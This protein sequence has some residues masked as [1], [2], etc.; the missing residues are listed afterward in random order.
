[1]AQIMRKIE[2]MQMDKEEQVLGVAVARAP[3]QQHVQERDQRQEDEHRLGHRA[4]GEMQQ[5]FAVV[6]HNRLAGMLDPLGQLWP[7]AEYAEIQVPAAGHSRGLLYST[8]LQSIVK[9]NDFEA[10]LAHIREGCDQEKSDAQNQV[11][12]KRRQVGD[13]PAGDELLGELPRLE[14][15]QSQRAPQPGIRVRQSLQKFMHE[16]PGARHVHI[17]GLAAVHAEPA[18]QHRIAIFAVRRRDYLA[19]LTGFE[20]VHASASAPIPNSCGAK[21]STLMISK[22]LV[23]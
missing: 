8:R 1:M 22:T 19:R 7:L 9:S 17:G 20:R 4:N 18:Q 11:Q 6:A 13:A 14:P 21:S 2:S 16:F 5:I 3:V 10:H 12:A 23:S 15:Q